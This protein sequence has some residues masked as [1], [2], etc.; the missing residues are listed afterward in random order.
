MRQHARD[1]GQ[2]ARPVR[3]VQVIEPAVLKG[4]LDVL[5]GEIGAERQASQ[6]AAGATPPSSAAPMALPPAPGTAATTAAAPSALARPVTSPRLD[7]RLPVKPTRATPARAAIWPA[8]SITASPTRATKVAAS[9]R[10]SCCRRILS[11][12]SD[13]S[14]ATLSRNG[15]ITRS[16]SSSFSTKPRSGSHVM[17]RLNSGE[18]WPPDRAPRLSIALYRADHAQAERIGH[19]PDRAEQ[20]VC[21]GQRRQ[22]RPTPF[23]DRRFAGFRAQHD[24]E[25]VLV[26]AHGGELAR[27]R[28]RGNH[29]LVRTRAQFALECLVRDAGEQSAGLLGGIVRGTSSP[30]RSSSTTMTRS[31]SAQVKEAR[32]RHASI[33]ESG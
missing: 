10:R 13:A 27:I 9:A 30:D 29:R 21:T 25:Q 33:A 3:F 14:V 2:Q 20:P 12:V 19:S 15:T 28:E 23:D 7:S 17:A 26:L 5:F 18:C 24:H 32:V 11:E 16:S 8:M 6:V 22:S 4:E 31:I 1:S